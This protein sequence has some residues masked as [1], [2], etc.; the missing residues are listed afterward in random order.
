VLNNGV[1]EYWIVD[2]DHH[3]TT[4]HKVFPWSMAFANQFNMNAN[5]QEYAIGLGSH[6]SPPPFQKV[7]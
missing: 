2:G 4:A 5:T 7:M 6:P 1:P 3:V